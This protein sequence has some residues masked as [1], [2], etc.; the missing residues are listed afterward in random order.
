MRKFQEMPWSGQCLKTGRWRFHGKVIGGGEEG[1]ELIV[2]M[3]G[4]L[5]YRSKEIEE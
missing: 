3:V 2:I 4:V 1:R 5:F